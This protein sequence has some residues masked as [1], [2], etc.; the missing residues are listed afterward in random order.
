MTKYVYN[1]LT[2]DNNEGRKVMHRDMNERTHKC[3][4]PKHEWETLGA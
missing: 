3:E 1:S 4:M 2:Q